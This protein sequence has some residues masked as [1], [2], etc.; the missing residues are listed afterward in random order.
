MRIRTIIAAILMT[1]VLAGASCERRTD[2]DNGVDIDPSLLVSCP[3]LPLVDVQE[4]MSMGV[5]YLEYS[6]LQTQYIEC[7]IRNDCLIEAVG[8]GAVKITCP[9]LEQLNENVRN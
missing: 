2:I 9:K 5:L 8:G 3:P 1:L 6:K 4:A 7:A